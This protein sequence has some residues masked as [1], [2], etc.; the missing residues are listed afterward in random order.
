MTDGSSRDP[1]P[2]QR[3]APGG[4]ERLLLLPDAD[5][6]GLATAL[7][8]VFRHGGGFG[9]TTPRRHFGRDS[10]ADFASWDGAQ[11]AASTFV[12]ILSRD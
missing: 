12:G 7:A 2:E 3:K 5:L 6:L 8:R 10:A 9:G 11:T 4:K 1:E